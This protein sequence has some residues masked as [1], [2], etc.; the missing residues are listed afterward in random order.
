M[1]AGQG[2]PQR[3][4]EYL[5]VIVFGH[6]LEENITIG[7]LEPRNIIQAQ[8]VELRLVNT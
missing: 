5:T 6:G 4:F 2:F 3:G 8:A 1:R 7:P